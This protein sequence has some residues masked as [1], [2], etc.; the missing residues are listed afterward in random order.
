MSE[1]QKA[2]D[3]A[4]EYNGFARSKKVK[5]ENGEEFTVRNPMFFKAPQTVAYNQLHHRINKCDKWPDAQAP[6]Q[7]MRSVQPDGTEVETFI[8]ARVIPGE[9]I[10]PYQED[11]VLVEP[12]YE[13]QVARIALGDE[14]YEKFEEAGGSPR[15]VV[16]VL[17]ELRRG[18][19]KRADADDKSVGSVSVLAAV[20]S[21]DSQ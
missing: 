4:D 9:Y 10:E 12:P 19:Q 2:Q 14:Q 6:E 3:Q 21:P 11:G 20:P 16:E 1:D 18:V 5:A 7:R 13:I 8:G 15:E 17:A